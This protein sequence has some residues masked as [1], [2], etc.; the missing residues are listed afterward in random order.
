[1]EWME[2]MEW[3]TRSCR[4][5]PCAAEVLNCFDWNLKSLWFSTLQPAWISWRLKL[6]THL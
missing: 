2:W 5:M 4:I 6:S 3:I 1:M